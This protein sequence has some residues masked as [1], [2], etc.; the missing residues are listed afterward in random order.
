MSTQHVCTPEKQVNICKSSTTTHFM[1]N[2]LLNYSVTECHATLYTYLL[3]CFAIYQIK[4]CL[5]IQLSHQV[6]FHYDK[7]ENIMYDTKICVLFYDKLEVNECDTIATSMQTAR[8]IS[9]KASVYL[10]FVSCR[11]AI[12][13]LNQLCSNMLCT[14]KRDHNTHHIIIYYKN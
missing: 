9:A 4:P 5:A 8:M 7:R 11:V 2:L 12:Q 10:K 1:V 13:L 6:I 14:V 3:D